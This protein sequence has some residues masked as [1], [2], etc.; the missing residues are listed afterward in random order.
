MGELLKKYGTI[1]V[2]PKQCCVELN[3]PIDSESGGIV[4]IHYDDIRFDMSQLEFY[5][6]VTALNLA[7]ENLKR[8]KGDTL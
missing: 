4:H 6:M 5:Q 8:I 2:G 3:A 7:S 1:N